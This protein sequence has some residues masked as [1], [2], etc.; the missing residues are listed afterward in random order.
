MI[1]DPQWGMSSGLG[2]EILA[3]SVLEVTGLGPELEVIEDLQ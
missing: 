3:G 1:E 2:G